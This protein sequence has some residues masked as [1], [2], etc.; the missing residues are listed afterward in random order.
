MLS[1]ILKAEVT[2]HQAAMRHSLFQLC[3]VVWLTSMAW[4]LYS[5]IAP[6]LLW[7]AGSVLL[8][9]LAYGLR[10][11]HRHWSVSFLLLLTA[12]WLQSKAFWV[13]LS[14]AIVWWLPA[15][16]MA[17]SIVAFFL[18][19]PKLDKLIFPVTIMGLM[20]VH[21]AWAAGELWLQ[22][23]T[24]SAAVGFLG[25]LIYIFAALLTALL[26]AIRDSRWSTFLRLSLIPV[27][28]LIAQT[29]IVVS[30]LV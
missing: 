25:T 6:Q 26:T 29:L 30:I 4:A 24:W 19:L 15:F 18:L 21:M 7:L 1:D 11:N 22:E 2:K 23:M 16:L 12:Q 27:S 17:A 9:M 3:H 5:H 14:D 28:Y 20:L 10:C 13:Q 8:S